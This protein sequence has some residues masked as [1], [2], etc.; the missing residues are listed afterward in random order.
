MATGQDPQR[1]AEKSPSKGAAAIEKPSGAVLRVR[2]HD[3]TVSLADKQVGDF[4]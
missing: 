2:C 1:T 3:V 4:D